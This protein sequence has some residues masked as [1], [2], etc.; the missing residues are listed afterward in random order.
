MR[1]LQL[2]SR[3]AVYIA[4]LIPLYGYC[5]D[6]SQFS[7]AGIRLGMSLDEARRASSEYLKISESA[8]AVSQAPRELQTRRMR[9]SYS[10]KEL[11]L[12]V[13]FEVTD[14]EGKAA[15]PVVVMVSYRPLSTGKIA[16]LS[17]F[18]VETYGEPTDRS[19]D[20]GDDG[21]LLWCSLPRGKWCLWGEPHLSYSKKDGL[22]LSDPRPL[23][24]GASAL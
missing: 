19:M 2:S 16:A 11:D 17:A 14:L 10:S 7:L 13:G 4:M 22:M 24:K 6:V 8:L 20:T 3:L 12:V 23:M 1:C 18:A 21:L 5:A 9:M 15:V